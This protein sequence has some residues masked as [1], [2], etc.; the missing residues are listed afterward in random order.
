MKKIIFT[1]FLFT[2]CSVVQAAESKNCTFSAHLTPGYNEKFHIT[3]SDG[4]S[5][6]V[7]IYRSNPFDHFRVIQISQEGLG[8]TNIYLDPKGEETITLPCKPTTIAYWL[9]P[10]PTQLSR[11]PNYRLEIFVNGKP[12]FD[13]VGKMNNGK[14]FGFKEILGNQSDLQSN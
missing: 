11:Y 9:K 1:L 6:E 12:V 3:T 4:N 10:T 13:Y 2:I 7:A 5:Q 8:G 14:T